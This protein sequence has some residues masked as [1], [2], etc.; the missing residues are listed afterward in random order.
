MVNRVQRAVFCAI[1]V[2]AVA[3]AWLYAGPVNP[4][5]GPI[6]ST[7]KTLTEVEPRI[8][9]NA[10]NTPGDNDATP[11]LYKITQPGSYY[12]TGNISLVNA[13]SAIEIATGG[14]TLDLNGYT[15]SGFGGV[16]GI[17]VTN[18]A[19]DHV[20]I[21]NGRVVNFLSGGVIANVSDVSVDRIAVQT[22]GAGGI[23]AG[24]RAQITHC[25]VVDC[26]TNSIGINAGSSSIVQ[27]CIANGNSLGGISAGPSSIVRNCTATFNTGTGIDA[28]T[29]S[30]VADCTASN[31]TASGIGPGNGSMVSHCS[32]QNNGGSGISADTGVTIS[33]CSVFYN[34]SVG[35]SAYSACIVADNAVHGNTTDGI[36]VLNN[37]TVRGNSCTTNGNG[38]DGAGIRTSGSDNRIEGNRCTAADR[39]IDVDGAGNII[40]KNTCTANTTNW[41][42]VAGNS[43]LIVQATVTASNFTGNAGGGGQGTT[44]PNAN[45]TY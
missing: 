19:S 42:I 26:H 17:L 3:A 41:T 10:T 6:T 28:S 38:G 9:M 24:M 21:R 31:N 40:I 14:V 45:F 23:R 27:D 37:C 16:T 43:F 34:T 20:N 25:S 44:D 35:I 32:A 30:T 12:L 2:L 8:A 33:N 4:P 18:A 1:P 22:C 7:G 13:K 29:A 39:G 36:F 15:I 5:A 11:S